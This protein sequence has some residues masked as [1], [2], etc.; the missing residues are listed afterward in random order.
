MIARLPAGL[1]TAEIETRP[2][3]HFLRDRERTPS[4]AAS[5]VRDIETVRSLLADAFAD[6]K[7]VV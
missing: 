3:P 5:A 7:A 6:D 4:E 2:P 1:T